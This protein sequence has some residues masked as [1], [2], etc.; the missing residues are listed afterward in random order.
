[1]TEQIPL[2]SRS[3]LVL[4]RLPWAERE[5]IER[6][7][8]ARAALFALSAYSPG[9]TQILA[10]RSDLVREIFLDL[11]FTR[12]ADLVNM[13][14]EVSALAKKARDPAEVKKILRLC[15]IKEMARLAV[16]DLTGRADLIEVM[17]TL[18]AL[19]ESCLRV[20]LA[21][22]VDLAAERFELAPEKLGIRPVIMGMGKLGAGELNY[23][24]DVD[25]IYLFK[26][27][28]AGGQ[29]PS[30]ERA[31][32]FIFTS[33]TKIMSEVTEDGFVFRVD[34]NLRPGGKDGAQAQ[35]LEKALKHYLNLGQ[36]WE[37][38][39]LLKARPVAGDIEAGN[40]FITEVMP[41]VFRRHL[42]YT[43]LEELQS[44]KKRFAR[45]NSARLLRRSPGRGKP[46]LDVK[47][48]P[49]GIRQIEFF[50]QALSLTF[51][52][53]LPHL[54]QARTL[55]AL[56]ALSREKIISEK[57]RQILSDAYVFLRTVEHRI[58]LRELTQTQLLPRDERVLA[59]LAR[60]MGPD[61]D[62]P[63]GFLK[64]LDR[65]MQRVARRFAILLSDPGERTKAA[66]DDRGLPDWAGKLPDILQNEEETKKILGEAG[67]ARPD[68][69]RA[70]CMNI[71]EG[72][73]LPVSLSRYRT[74]LERLGPVLIAA[75]AKTS[76]P[77][78]AI[79]HLE[80]FLASIG[81]KAGFLVLLEENHFLVDSLATLFG[82][83]DHL[84]EILIN[85]PAILDSLVDR[86]SAVFL[87]SKK[88]HDDRTGHHAQPGRRSR[89]PVDRH[90]S[91]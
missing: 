56:T 16:R 10:V 1:M 15:R 54:R 71:M 9:L 12:P 57:D 2:P 82:A 40:A 76:D 14:A 85:H 38:M 50:A 49:G 35:S 3:E 48:S 83:S 8:Q 52:G 22:S 78:R 30:P 64:E 4:G 33:V 23:S 69:A 42:D 62:A 59:A 86:R 29:D 73:F 17:A 47:L 75:A 7:Q 46:A 81:P 65:H 11:V 39:A 20:A 70:A 41:F 18:S 21:V 26:K 53:R 80:R 5:V 36:P 51:G 84:S 32:D 55:E 88:N 77:D 66:I 34:L 28:E 74:N 61:E 45:D 60:S 37:R 72:A 6:D 19:A 44:L 79:L 63:A 24:S 43:T 91:L 25:L 13:A 67:F 68:A 87:K 58:Q 31:A 90:P 27:T 89:G